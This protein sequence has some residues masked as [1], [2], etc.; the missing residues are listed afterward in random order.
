MT[1]EMNELVTEFCPIVPS[2]RPYTFCL[3]GFQSV[4]LLP[5]QN[6]KYKVVR[7]LTKL[8][9]L[10]SATRPSGKSGRVSQ[11]SIDYLQVAI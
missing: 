1:Q 3:I 8:P 7:N 5:K 9:R 11:H 2:L 10:F 4:L 6:R